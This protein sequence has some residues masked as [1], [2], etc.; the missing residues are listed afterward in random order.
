M[1]SIDTW[2]WWSLIHLLSTH[3]VAQSLLST[4]NVVCQTHSIQPSFVNPCQSY[5]LKHI[6]IEIESWLRPDLISITC[7]QNVSMR[8]SSLVNISNW[9]FKHSGDKISYFLPGIC[10]ACNNF[11]LHSTLY[12]FY[13][14]NNQTY[15]IYLSSIVYL[16]QFSYTKH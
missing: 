5:E 14:E 16:Y 3:Y 1:V 10:Y 11:N 15:S 13:L 12:N 2:T 7:E 4:C 6:F 8:I 9:L